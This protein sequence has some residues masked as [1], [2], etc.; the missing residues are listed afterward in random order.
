MQAVKPA[1]MPSLSCFRIR[2]A[3][4]GTCATSGRTPASSTAAAATSQQVTKVA[5]CAVPTE[6]RPAAIAGPTST[7]TACITLAAVFALV[8]SSGVRASQGSRAACTGR[9]T[10][11]SPPSNATSTATSMAC[12]CPLTAAPAAP[13]SSAL[14]MSVAVS[15]R[16]R[17]TRS[18][19]LLTSGTRIA[20]DSAHSTPSKPTYP[21]PPARYRYTDATV[22]AAMSPA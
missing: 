4:V 21:A 16:S 11:Q 14:G 12:P 2:A 22:Y 6:S 13:S 8:S 15:S 20:A 1:A 5:D 19:Q 3:R 17:R 9:K 7:A 10:L 18:D